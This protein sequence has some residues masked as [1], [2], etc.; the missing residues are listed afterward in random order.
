MYVFPDE[1]P[2]DVDPDTFG[3]ANVSATNRQFADRYKQREPL[4]VNNRV[5]FDDDEDPN[6]ID[7][8]QNFEG[9]ELAAPLF[10]S[11]RLGKE[12]DV[13]DSVFVFPAD[14]LKS[15]YGKLITAEGVSR[16]KFIGLLVTYRIVRKLFIFTNP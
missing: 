1:I 5:A 4:K 12:H 16:R 2:E 6:Q 14:K 9:G 3:K 10:V 13:A 11:E 8:A 15:K 7:E